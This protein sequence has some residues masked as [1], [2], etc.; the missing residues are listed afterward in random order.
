MKKGEIVFFGASTAFFG[1]MLIQAIGLM[2]QG[3]PGEIGSGLWPFLALGASAVL[4]VVLLAGS[5]QKYRR[6]APAAEMP[7]PEALAEK[8][9]QRLTVALSAACFL[10]YMIAVPWVGFIL[11]TFVFIPAFA[12]A[13][14]ERRKTVLLIAPVLLTAIIVGVF[15]K[16]ITIPFPKGVGVFAE[17]SRLF[18]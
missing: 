14:G 5:I 7:T 13:L 9:R 18:Y 6:A 16:F 11:A 10:V 12:L 8:R 2:G 1:F 4:S 15:A 3:R 17:F